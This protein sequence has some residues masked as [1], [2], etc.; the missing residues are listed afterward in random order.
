MKTFDNLCTSWSTGL[1]TGNHLHFEISRVPGYSKK[2]TDKF[3]PN[4]NSS[5]GIK[6]NSTY[7]GSACQKE[8]NGHARICYTFNKDEAIQLDAF[9][10]TRSAV[11]KPYFISK[12]VTLRTYPA[13]AAPKGPSL[14]AGDIVVILESGRNNYNNTWY[15]VRRLN[16]SKQYYVYS[17]YIGKQ[18]TS[19]TLA[20]P[21]F[22]GGT[23]SVSF[24]KA[25]TVKIDLKSAA[26]SGC[27]YVAVYTCGSKRKTATFTTKSFEYNVGSIG[28][29]TVQIYTQ[30]VDSSFRVS[31]ASISKTV[32]VL[33]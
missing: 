8:I 5:L 3:D 6:Y 18:V 20:K 4:P 11:S 24:L 15:K 21:A 32:I 26:P 16:D 27:T 33:W 7:S 17:S 12:A 2:A 13:D 23:L 25:K 19:S 14:K 9:Q 28:V 29:W 31:S 30:T 22:S 10:E 1:S